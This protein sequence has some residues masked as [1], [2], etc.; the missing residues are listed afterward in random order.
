MKKSLSFSSQIFQGFSPQTLSFFHQL[1]ANNNR[2]WFAKHRNDYLRYVSEPMKQLVISLSPMIS[3]LD[4][5]VISA[6]HR[7]ASRIYRDTRFSNDKTPYRPRLWFAFKREV[8]RWTETPTYFFQIEEKKYLFG[9]GMYSAS[10]ATMR[11]F[12]QMIDD[13]PNY[14]RNIIEPI[15]KKK[16]FKLDVDRYKR[17]LPCEHPAII[18]AWYQSK[19]I[20]VLAQREPDKILFSSKLVDFLI[21]RFI[22]LKPLYDFLWQATVL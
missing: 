21:D 12:R 10:P 19:S 14:F 1:D 6:P 18:D 9:M 8:D 16:T 15:R 2:D 22:F 13:N 11:R 17:P 3:E 7:I 20:A 5:Q 4:P